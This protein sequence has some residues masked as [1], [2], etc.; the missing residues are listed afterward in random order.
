VPV[1]DGDRPAARVATPPVTDEAFLDLVCSDDELVRA[2]FEAIVAEEWP[3]APS[4]PRPIRAAGFPER[5]RSRRSRP[6]PH[7]PGP[8]TSHRPVRPVGRQRS[9]PA[10][11]HSVI[12]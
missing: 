12:S 10:R 1:M 3:S 7:A 9:P 6:V 11:E 4:P 5:G 2:A 8:V